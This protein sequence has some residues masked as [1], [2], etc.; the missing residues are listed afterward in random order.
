MFYAPRYVM[1]VD[2][3]Q[4]WLILGKMLLCIWNSINNLE[5]GVYYGN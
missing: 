4:N 2:D 3:N 5:S 1:A